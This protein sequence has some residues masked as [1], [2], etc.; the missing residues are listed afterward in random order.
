MIKKI[1][2]NFILTIFFLLIIFLIILSTIGIKTNRFN[3]L[4]SDKITQTKKLS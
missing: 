4:I 1:V 3:K 2:S